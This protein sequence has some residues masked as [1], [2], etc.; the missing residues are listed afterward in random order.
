MRL[1][2][3]DKEEQKIAR[4]IVNCAGFFLSCDIEK[5]LCKLSKR[6]ITDCDDYIVAYTMTVP[7]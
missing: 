6:L 1:N 5:S 7:C 3:H 4:L 2:A